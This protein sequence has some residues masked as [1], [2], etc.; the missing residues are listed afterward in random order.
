[1]ELLKHVA[2][3]HKKDKE[4]EDTKDSS[5]KDEENKHTENEN[6]VTTDHVFVF[7]GNPDRVRV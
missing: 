3:H 7:K 4:K 5:Q 2:K 1:M 6:K